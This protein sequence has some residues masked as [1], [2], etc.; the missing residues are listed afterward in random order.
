METAQQ[1]NPLLRSRDGSYAV[2]F[3]LILV[4]L[5]ASLFFVLDIGFF[6]WVKTRYQNAAELAAKAAADNICYCYDQVDL[7]DLVD[8]IVQG[9]GLDTSDPDHTTTVE[10]GFYD[11]HNQFGDY[12]EY[13]DFVTESDSEFPDEETANA[14]MVTL[15]GSVDSLTGFY[16]ARDIKG[17]AV[18]YM[19]R[20]SMVSKERVY[21]W[22]NNT[23]TPYTVNNGN[24]YGEDKINLRNVTLNPKNVITATELKPNDMPEYNLIQN[25]LTPLDTFIAKMKEKADITYTLLDK[26][27][28]PFYKMDDN[29]GECFFDFSAPHKNPDHKIIFIDLPEKSGGNTIKV[30]LR[31][32]DSGGAGNAVKNMTIISERKITIETSDT[33]NSSV[34][35]LGGSGFEQLNLISAD[36]I[37]LYIENHSLKGVNFLCARF[38]LYFDANKPPLQ[39]EYYLR[40]ISENRL[41]FNSAYEFGEYHDFFLKFGPPC[42]LLLPPAMGLLQ[43]GSG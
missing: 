5:L 17:A 7:S 29:K 3:A 16:P 33:Y 41:R 39:N 4:P 23:H 14:V 43:T 11:T 40:V 18:A 26:N 34:V 31:P 12:T 19:P 2:T 30:L 21:L 42:P 20:M 1:G 24:I 6:F 38:N 13:K 32:P 9:S 28:D 22:N 25:H 15:S 37:N 36:N 10:T 35:E 27:K 8:E